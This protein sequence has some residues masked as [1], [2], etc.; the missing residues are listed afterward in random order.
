[1]S[2]VLAQQLT[3]SFAIVGH[4][5]EPQTVHVNSRN[6]ELNYVLTVQLFHPLAVALNR[7][8]QK[9]VILIVC[10][11]TPHS[12]CYCTPHSH[13]FAHCSSLCG[14][15]QCFQSDSGYFASFCH[16]LCSHDFDQN[17]GVAD[18]QSL[19]ICFYIRRSRDQAF[20]TKSR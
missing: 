5:T 3:H 18:D 13:Y 19:S 10:Y 6:A 11:C 17:L 14:H 9:L 16:P 12:L 15:F 2:V 4:Q 1:M 20:G 8:R 7:L